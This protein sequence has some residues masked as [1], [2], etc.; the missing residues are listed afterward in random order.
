MTYLSQNDS[1]ASL[2]EDVYG[3][4]C[5]SWRYRRAYL[6]ECLGYLPHFFRSA[7]RSHW[8]RVFVS[9]H[10]VASAC[11]VSHMAL[12]DQPDIWNRGALH[13]R[14]IAWVSNRQNAGAVPAPHANPPQDDA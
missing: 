9:T 4:N 10:R 2:P 6:A 8:P 12:Q 5:Q 1:S 14:L 7:P 11:A 3:V 13:Q